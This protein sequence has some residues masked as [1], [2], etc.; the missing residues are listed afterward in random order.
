MPGEI[1]IRT[2]GPT[3]THRL[4]KIR[5]NVG[6]KELSPTIREIV[7]HRDHQRNTS[8]DEF[9]ERAEVLLNVFDMRELHGSQLKACNTDRAI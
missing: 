8:A 1:S 3:L 6:T 7:R 4:L 2:L 9:A 5:A